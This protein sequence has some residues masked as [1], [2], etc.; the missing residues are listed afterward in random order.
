LNTVQGETRPIV[1]QNPVRSLL[2][3]GSL[4][5]LSSYGTTPAASR[6]RQW[7]P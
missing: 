7:L 4:V 6:R 1:F 5:S 2:Q 3:Q